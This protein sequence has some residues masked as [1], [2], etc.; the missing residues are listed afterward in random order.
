MSTRHIYKI[1]RANL[2]C[3]SKIL[4]S[5]NGVDLLSLNLDETFS[6]LNFKR[7]DVLHVG[8]QGIANSDFDRPDYGQMW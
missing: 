6:A 5:F 8:Q 4:F 3:N 1:L 2:E 7:Y